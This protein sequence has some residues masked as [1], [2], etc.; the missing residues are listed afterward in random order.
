VE[1]FLITFNL[2]IESNFT[3]VNI[4]SE[5]WNTTLKSF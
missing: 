4:T 1:V 3:Q 2:V 5:H